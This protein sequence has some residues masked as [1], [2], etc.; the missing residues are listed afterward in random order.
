[1]GC[2]R[3]AQSAV[4]PDEMACESL[5]AVLTLSCSHAAA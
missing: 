4:Y 5:G 2:D 1:M 3:I